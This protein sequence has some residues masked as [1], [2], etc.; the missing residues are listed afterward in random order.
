M[1]SCIQ[2]AVN[3]N[4]VTS[5]A[6]LDYSINGK[7]GFVHL[8]CELPHDNDCNNH[9]TCYNTNRHSVNIVLNLCKKFT[10]LYGTTWTPQEHLLN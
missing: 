9:C 6:V 4:P 1:V 8:S 10:C 3:V 5:D 7:Q 2:A